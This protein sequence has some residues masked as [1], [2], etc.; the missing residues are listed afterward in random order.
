M[1]ILLCRWK[2]KWRGRQWE[3]EK[4]KETQEIEVKRNQEKVAIK[5]K[6]KDFE[7][8]CCELHS[9]AL[10][11][12]L[13]DQ[14]LRFNEMV[15]VSWARFTHPNTLHWSAQALHHTLRTGSNGY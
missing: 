8:S 4:E 11:I 7:D 14:I 12:P 15:G 5:R 10:I 9:T 2:W 1:E 3:G 6:G 13:V